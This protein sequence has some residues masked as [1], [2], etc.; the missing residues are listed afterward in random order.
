MTRKG[1]TRSTLLLW[2]ISSGNQSTT[3]PTEYMSRC[4]ECHWN[5]LVPC[6]RNRSRTDKSVRVAGKTSWTRFVIESRGSISWFIVFIAEII[7]IIIVT[8]GNLDLSMSTNVKVRED[9][10]RLHV[11]ILRR[12]LRFP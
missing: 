6:R 11:C 1:S 2:D 4:C 10:Q 9:L 8:S 5:S 7:V 12:V 3:E